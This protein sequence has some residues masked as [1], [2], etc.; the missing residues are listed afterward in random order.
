MRPYYKQSL[1]SKSIIL[2]FSSFLIFASSLSLA[3]AQKNSN[4]TEIDTLLDSADTLFNKKKYNE[5]IP[6]YDKILAIN[7]SEMMLSITKV[8]LCGSCTNIMNHSRILTK[9][10]Q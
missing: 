7:A 8:F 1:S 9:F 10:L 5:S 3:N 6:Y 2:A 4:S